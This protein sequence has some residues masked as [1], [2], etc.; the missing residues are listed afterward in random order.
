VK[1][2]NTR[3]KNYKIP[4]VPSCSTIVTL[5][6]SDIIPV[7]NFCTV[8]KLINHTESKAVGIKSLSGFC[9]LKISDK[10]G[11]II[12]ISI[13]EGS[14]RFFA[15]LFRI[16]YKFTGD[17]NYVNCS[18]KNPEEIKPKNQNFNEATEKIVN[19]TSD[20]SKNGFNLD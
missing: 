20:N 17:G 16:S 8:V 10:A 13:D 5:K 18:D 4:N 7:T 1:F 19:I 6:P 11:Y 14:Y 2:C 15:D 12:I 3:N 9:D